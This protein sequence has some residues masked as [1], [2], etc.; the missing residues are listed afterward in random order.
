[1]SQKYSYEFKLKVVEEYL[2][3]T[4]GYTLL[5]KK[6]HISTT[7]LIEKWVNQFKTNG[8]EGRRIYNLSATTIIK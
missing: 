4:L 3:G 2:N 6:H 7:S 1:M 5:A 8:K